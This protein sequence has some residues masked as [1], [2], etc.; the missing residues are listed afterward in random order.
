M[1]FVNG[2]V[3]PVRTTDKEKY[4]K[5]AV[6]MSAW[7]RKNGATAVVDAW[8]V[9]VPDG[10]IT[11]FKRAVKAEADETIVYSWI[12]WPDKATSDAAMAKMPTDPAMKAVDMPGDMQR[13]IFGGFEPMY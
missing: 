10:K 4:R 5:A 1:T 2:A 12:V 7:F 3:I 8:G 11:D 9:D 13:M 6:L